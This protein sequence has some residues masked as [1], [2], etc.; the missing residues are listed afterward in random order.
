MTSRVPLPEPARNISYPEI[1]EQRLANGLE[2]LVI[3]D[4]HLPKVSV[5]LALPVGR[6]HNPDQ[7]LALL[8]LAVE[9][10]K[11]GTEQHSSR[12]I[13]EQM[14][15][16]AIHY[17]SDISM[18]HV[19][20]SLEVL[21]NYL[22]P[23]VELFSDMVCHPSFPPQEL[24]R[25]KVRWR[26][27]LAAQRSQPD[28]LA[29]ER[30]FHSL[31]PGHPYAKVSIPLEHLESTRRDAAEEIY[32]SHFHPGEGLLIFAGPVSLK[33]ATQL[34]DRFFGEWSRQNASPVEYPP[35][36]PIDGGCIS[37]VH[38][39][40]SVQ[41]KIV[42]AARAVPRTHP[43]AVPLK[44]VNQ[45]L[46]GGA[47]ARLFLNLRET[48]GYTYGAYS[49]MKTYRHDGIFLLGANVKADV[50]SESI[51]EFLSELDGMQAGPPTGE[52]LS[53]CQNELTGAFLRQTERAASVAEM[54][55]IRRLYQ[56]PEDYYETFLPAVRSVK[57]EGVLEMSQRFLD[58]QRVLITVVG[59]RTRVE[60]ALEQ[61]GK[62]AVY[63]TEGNPI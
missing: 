11:E 30:I 50:T 56:L 21:E 49:R 18:E 46:G 53:R 44:V 42:V 34:T 24:D 51:Q 41:S 19:L 29:G 13:A 39:P 38:R 7:N 25:L 1:S 17:E 3:Q 48:K 15:Q 54:E 32:R 47:S 33:Q 14:D 10:I 52:E 20:L 28:F 22:E 62:V 63:D 37:L 60:K 43:E 12:E 6:V 45:I 59:D 55:L 23:A 16:W 35:L 36:Q 8:E 57:A 40:H 26:S 58:S 2:V 27:A 5:K 31:Y 4:N 61:F 9:M